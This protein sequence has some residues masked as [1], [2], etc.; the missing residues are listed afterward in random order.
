[1][2]LAHHHLF[3]LHRYLVPPSLARALAQLPRHLAEVSRSR[4]LGVIDPMTEA[5]DLL[6]IIS[7]YFLGYGIVDRIQ[8]KSVCAAW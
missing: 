5:H 7:A 3:H 2:L 8:L 6:A 4:V 1:M